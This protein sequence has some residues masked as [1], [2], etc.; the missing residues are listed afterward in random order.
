MPELKKIV[1]PLRA[2]LLAAL[3]IGTAVYLAENGNAVIAGLLVAIPVSLPAIWFI[4][5]DKTALRDYAWS[6]M[7]GFIT[8]CISVII[9]YCLLTKFN[10]EKKKAIITSMGIWFIMIILVYLFLIKQFQK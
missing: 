7:L 10:F 5:N 6:F 3:V 8:Y 1:R 2:A 9:F 4:E